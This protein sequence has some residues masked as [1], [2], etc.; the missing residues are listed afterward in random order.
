MLDDHHVYTEVEGI[1]ETLCDKF[2]ETVIKIQEDDNMF[3]KPSYKEIMSDMHI[4]KDRF[5]RLLNAITRNRIYFKLE[6]G[7]IL[8][9]SNIVS[10]ID[11]SKRFYLYNSPV[12]HFKVEKYKII[13]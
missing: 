6:K 8:T 10:S 12:Y 2:F 3:G 1:K 7:Y 11:W 9:G 4:G 13:K 5:Q